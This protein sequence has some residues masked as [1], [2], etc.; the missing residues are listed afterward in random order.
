W[1]KWEFYHYLI[2]A[3]IV[4]VL[5]ALILYFI[6][7]FRIKMPAMVICGLGCLAAGL[8]IGMLSM[9][10]MG[11]HLEKRES[12]N[13]PAGVDQAGAMAMRRGGPGG[14][15]A[16]NAMMNR[17]KGGDGGGM[18]GRGKGGGGGGGRGG[19]SPKTQLATLVD[20]LDV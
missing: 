6:P 7:G 18:A 5:L 2:A 1:T 20:K 19:P 3:G 17:G 11:Y 15:G 8:G 12:G 13:E 9:V 14:A 16:M 4:V 10:A